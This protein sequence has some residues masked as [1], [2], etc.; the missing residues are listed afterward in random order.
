MHVV[1]LAMWT[2]AAVG[3]LIA[4]FCCIW[5]YRRTTDCATHFHRS[6]VVEMV[7]TAVPCVI[8][9]TAAIPAARLIWSNASL[10]RPMA[11]AP[12][13]HLP[14]PHDTHVEYPCA[15]KCPPE[16]VRPGTVVDRD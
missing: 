16:R 15:A 2:L 8:L 14:Y 3:T 9:I 10:S 13:S 6:P 5:H 4:M 1:V 11:N 12:A 7:W